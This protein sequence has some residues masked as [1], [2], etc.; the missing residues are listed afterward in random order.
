[1]LA[2]RMGY[3]QAGQKK[4]PSPDMQ[5]SACGNEGALYMIAPCTRLRIPAATA[6]QATS[7]VR[8]HN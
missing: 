5:I 1:M 7:G 8:R 6:R 4:A 3:A 2:S